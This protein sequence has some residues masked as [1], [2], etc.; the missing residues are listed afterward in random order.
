[1]ALVVRSQGI[2]IMLNI[3][4]NPTVNAARAIAYQINNAIN[5]FV[6]SF[7]QAVRPQITKLV[8]VDEKDKMLSLVIS[9]SVISYLLMS[10]IAIPLLV[11]MPFVLSFWLGNVPKYTII[12]SRLVIVTA[13]VDT[14]GNP[15]TTAVCAS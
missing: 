14:L 6:N 7:Y 12:F 4:F 10:L 3:F 11:E 9:T 15:L 5:Q 8:A 13:M 1:M 2:N